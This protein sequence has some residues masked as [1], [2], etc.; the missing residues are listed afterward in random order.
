MSEEKKK[1][2]G[3]PKK[4]KPVEKTKAEVRDENNTLLSEANR[5]LDVVTQKFIDNP[6]PFF[7]ERKKEIAEVIVQYGDLQSQDLEE[8]GIAQRDYALLLTERLMKPF[9]PRYGASATKHTALSL[10]LTNEFYWQEIVLK[11]ADK[12]NFIPSIYD[13]FSLLGISK[14]TFDNYQRGGTEEMRETCEMIL[15][16]FVGY[17]QRKGMKKEC[18][19]IMAMFTLKTTFRQRENDVPQVVVANINT[20]A[21]ERIGKLARQYGFDTWNGDV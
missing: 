9:A 14:Q 19:T 2:V 18:D 21:Q 6:Q 13:L 12:M 7:D 8:T 15:D 5:Q 1:K 4:E 11:L 16:K 10:Q 20:T 3:R 17:Y